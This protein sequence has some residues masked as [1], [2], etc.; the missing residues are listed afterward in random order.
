MI[1]LTP[2]KF[3][4]FKLKIWPQISSVVTVVPFPEF[5]EV[6]KTPALGMMLDPDTQLQWV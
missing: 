1:K 3:T 2:N 4:L 6:V 5:R